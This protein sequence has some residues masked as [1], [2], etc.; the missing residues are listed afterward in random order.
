MK[1]ILDTSF[2]LELRKGNGRA[3]EVL[4]KESR[5]AEDILISS[6]T[7]Y[8][9]LV[10]AYY[11]WLKRRDAGERLWIE[12]LLAWLTVSEL[13]EGIV[14]RAAEVKAEALLKGIPLPD[15]DLLIALSAEP[16]AKL[17]TF[18]EDHER[19]KELLSERGID[20]L[21]LGRCRRSS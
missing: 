6:L 17:L 5:E 3:A 1:L 16:P 7:E 15:M 21:F 11:L 12:D 18:D 20:V 8:E 9:L 2:I 4:R 14:R 13:N 10:G 19:M